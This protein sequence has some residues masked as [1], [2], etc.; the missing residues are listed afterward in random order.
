MVTKKTSTKRRD[1][2]RSEYDLSELENPVRG[3]YYTRAAAGTNLVLLDPDIADVFQDAKSVND[4]LR[5]LVTVARAKVGRRV[6]ARR[7]PA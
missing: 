1:E 4:A 6:R 3:K 7:K 5:T 2:L